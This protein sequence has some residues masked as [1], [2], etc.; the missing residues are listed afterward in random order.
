MSEYGS[1]PPRDPQNG[2]SGGNPDGTGG[3]QPSYGQNQPPYG[4]GQPSYGQDQYGQGQYGQGQYGQ[5]Q[6]GQNSGEQPTYGQQPGQYGQAPQY[7]QGQYGQ[8]QYGQQPEYGS[9]EQQGQYGQGQ[10]GQQPSYGSNPY[11]QQPAYGQFG[12]QGY[13]AP[14]GGAGGIPPNI[15][16]ASM[17][18]RLGAFLIDALILTVALGILAVLILGLPAASTDANDADPAIMSGAILAF[19]GVTFLITLAY[20][21]ALV[22]LRGATPGK[23]I[24]GIRIVR[25][26]DGQVPGWVP[27]ILRWLIP[28]IGGFVCGI[29]Q[30][31]VYLSPFFDSSGRRQGWHDM[32]A[33]TVV[34]KV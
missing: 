9:P 25:T 28:F 12:N 27:A 30:I 2:G 31:V 11:G 5:G 34:I 14:M 32:A 13:G 1:N 18:R 17:G 6:Y 24:L 33:K 29:G 19:Y 3:G 7:G 16:F 4:Q 21:I 8:G 23:M 22:A 20:Q 26:E 15:E 10:Y